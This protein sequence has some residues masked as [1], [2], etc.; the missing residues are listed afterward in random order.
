MNARTRILFVLIVAALLG[1]VA[2]V[3]FGPSPAA[4]VPMVVAEAPWED[5]GMRVPDLAA[6]DA[7]WEARAP[8]GA[9]PEPEE[10]PA[11]PPPPPPVPVGIVGT[12]RAQQAL[13][14]IDG[15]SDLRLGVGGAL[16][17][18]GRV[19]AIEGMKVTWIDGAGQ[20]HERRMFIDPLELPPPDQESDAPRRR[21]NAGT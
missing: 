5:V 14:R 1:V 21:T 6:A 9:A 7:P 12:G 17:D 3:L 4:V 20:R 15:T 10:P 19:L 2:N 11:P 16:P 18:G 8:W 13:F